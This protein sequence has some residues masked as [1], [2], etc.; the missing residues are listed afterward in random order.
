MKQKNFLWYALMLI[1]IFSFAQQKGKIM[2]K[3]TPKFETEISNISKEEGINYLKQ[4]LLIDDYENFTVVKTFNDE[5]G[6]EHI[7]LQQTYKNVEV[8][9]GQ[10]TL[11]IKNNQLKSFNGDYFTIGSLNIQPVLSNSAAFVKAVNVVKAEKYLWQD[12]N[13]AALLNYAKPQGDL[14]ILP[15]I[16]EKNSKTQSQPKLAYRFDIYATK[17]VS[18]AYIYVD[19]NTGEFLYKD[20]II[21]HATVTGTAETRYSGTKSIKTESYNGSYRLRDASRGNGIETFDMNTGTNYSNAVDFTDN[22]NNWTAAEYNNSAKDNAALDAHYGAQMTYD[23]WL[24]KHNRNSFDGNGAK[25]KSYVHYD[26]AYDNAYWNG[27]VMTY[28]DGSG[29]YFDALTSLDVAAHEIG[30]AIMSH[31]AN[32]TYSYESG[33]MNES[34]S[35]I[36][37]ASVEYFADPNKQTWLIGEDIERRSGHAALRSMSNPKSEGQP[38]TYQGTNWATGSSDNGGVHTNSGVLN[39]WFYLVSVGGSGTNDNGDAY[40]VSGIT[41]DKAA[42]IAYRMQNVYLTSSS[43]YADARIAGIQSAKDLYGADSAEEIA[44]TNAFYAVGVGAAYNSGGGSSY[45]TSK[46]NS[47]ADE[48]IQKVVLN[49]INNS[50]TGGNGYSDFTSISTDLTVSTAYTITITPKWTGTVY[51]E[52]Y[53]VW[54]DY[55]SDGDFS[56]SGELVWSKAASKTT[57][58]SGSFTVPAGA[59]IGT[60]RMRVSMKYNGIPTACETFSYGEVEDYTINIIDNTA[61]TQAP[62]APYNLVASNVTQTTVD[63]AW[64]AATDNVG[65]TG[66]DVYKDGSLLGSTTGTNAQVTGL[67]ANT[68]YSFYVKAKDASGNISDSSNSISVTTQAIPSSSCTAQVTAFPYN[69]SFENTLGLW[70]QA[71]DDDF[72]WTVKTGSTPSSNTGPSSADNGSYYVYMESSSPNYSTKRAILNSPCIDLTGQTQAIITFKYHMY[73]ASTMGS[74]ALEASTDN[75][76]SW[77]NIWNKSGNQGN[78]WLTASVDLA[79]YIGATVK[80]RFNGVTGTTWKGDM[81]IDAF[82]VSSGST[83]PSNTCTETTLTITFDDYPAETSW[84]IKDSNGIVIFSGG[85][86]D[87]QAKKSTITIPNCIDTGCYTFNMRDSYGDGICCSY[88]NGSFSLTEDASGTV[89]ASGGSFTS[90]ST[91]NFCVGGASIYGV[92]NLDDTDELIKEVIIYPN[93]TNNFL[94]VSLRDKKMK[95]FSIINLMGQTVLKD[96]ISD[97]IINVS[98]LKNG[99]YLIKFNS[100]KKQII[101]KFIKQ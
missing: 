50:S 48:Y 65:V 99:V 92:V 35:D 77:T 79:P 81:A 94:K 19:A 66:Y 18:R 29:T 37:G 55:N 98:N 78:S 96:K 20:N 72:D 31:T 91:T 39:Y 57:P 86:Y 84:D 7:K 73:G 33:A 80:L 68:S 101:R 52:G 100:D 23:Y 54:I 34:F 69:E 8:V 97:K 67:I 2:V 1:T 83:P 3:N 59:N 30:H 51:S 15:S 88:G 40:S 5:L 41:I 32:L 85:T 62:S 53:A 43:N 60:T 82:S 56:D 63:L 95:T 21:M 4:R 46:G 6:F 9:F 22:D 71:S 64:I 11:H 25:I 27:S 14:V 12:K 13:Q 47:V 10:Y 26:N 70:S 61:D 42:K 75:G 49:T 16:I 17:P 74:L 89:L 87:S 90:V 45:C 93:P 28:G 44:V 58:V 38:D 36:W 24:S 76:A